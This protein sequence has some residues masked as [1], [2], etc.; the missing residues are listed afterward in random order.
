MGY[1]VFVVAGDNT[2]LQSLSTAVTGEIELSMLQSSNEALWE[3][4]QIAPDVLIADYD[5][6]GFSGL[7]LADLVPNFAPDTRVILVARSANPEVAEQAAQRG[8]FRFIDRNL[9]AVLV[10]DAL[11]EALQAAPPPRPVEPEP[12]Y[13]PEPEPEPQPQAPSRF[14]PP[15]SVSKAPAPAKMG[16]P[17]PVSKAPTPVAR[18]TAP[19]PAPASISKGPPPVSPRPTAPPQRSRTAPPPVSARP[20]PATRSAPPPVSPRPA[21]QQPARPAATPARPATTPARPAAPIQQTPPPAQQTPPPASNADDVFGSKL[22]SGGSLVLTAETLAPLVAKLKDLGVQLGAQSTI[23]TDRW[24]VPL[25]EEGHTSLPLPPFL[26]LLATSFSTMVDYTR[27]LHNDPGSG[28][29]MHEGD[30]YDFYIFDVG[31]QFLLVMVFDKTIAA[32]KLGTVWL[33]AKRAVRELAD[34]LE[35]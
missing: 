8:V 10:L 27:Q 17:P 25:V 16:G 26:P 11:D 1:R 5:L 32:P 29:Y 21:A 3:L 34:E 9:T 22:R 18:T 14:A 4:Q 2:V 28:L 19:A 13:E 20:A 35:G 31:K 15:P 6:P 33:Y 7:D 30:I 12:V 23:L 24:G